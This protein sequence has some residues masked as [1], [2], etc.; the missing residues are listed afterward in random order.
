MTMQEQQDK[1]RQ[2]MNPY[3][4]E[5]DFKAGDKVQISTKNWKTQR[6]SYKLDY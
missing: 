6:P 2:D 4:R 1:K 3:R 5:V